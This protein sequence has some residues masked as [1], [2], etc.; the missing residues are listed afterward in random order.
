MERGVEHSHIG[1]ALHGLF[2]GLDAH[3]VG[4]IVQRA[5]RNALSDG[6]LARFVDDAGLGERHAAVQ[7][8]VTDGVDLVNVGNHADLFVDQHFQHQLH[9]LGVIGDGLL[10]LLLGAAVH[11]VLVNQIGTGDA[12]ALDQ[13][14]GHDLFVRHV[15]QLIFQ[16]RGTGV[17]NQNFHGICPPARF[18]IQIDRRSAWGKPARRF[19]DSISPAPERR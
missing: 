16:R 8:A 19:M 15:D 14:L 11:A 9:G 10:V 4:R 13:A 2:A 18:F 17:D 1:H 6:R 7:H 5:E 12:D 3:Q